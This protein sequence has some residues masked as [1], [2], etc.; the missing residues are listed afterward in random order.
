MH[1]FIYTFVRRL[2]CMMQGRLRWVPVSVYV[3]FEPSL[4]LCF[5]SSECHIGHV[6]FCVMKTF[7]NSKKKLFTLLDL[8]V[9]SLRRGHANLL[10][11]VPILTDDPRRESRKV[12]CG[13]PTRCWHTYKSVIRVQATPSLWAGYDDLAVWAPLKLPRWYTMCECVWRILHKKNCLHF[14]ICACHPCAGAMLFFSVS[15]QF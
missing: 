5:C 3:S 14:S 11:I 2:F 10:C 1:T 15:F 7:A 6:F 8:C 12:L 4:S 9:S 13:M